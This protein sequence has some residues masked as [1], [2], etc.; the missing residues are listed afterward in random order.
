[1]SDKDLVFLCH[2]SDDKDVVRGLHQNL[3]HDG[4][5]CWL[6][7]VDLVG[8]QNW[9]E[10]ITKAIR[11]SRFVLVCLS[12]NSVS[13]TGYV[14]KELRR[15]LDVADEQP[16]GR[17]FIIPV[18]LKPCEIPQSLSKWHCV[19]L[20]RLNGYPK[21]LESLGVELPEEWLLSEEVLAADATGTVL[22]PMNRINDDH[23]L[24]DLWDLYFNRTVGF[25]SLRIQRS[26][27]YR[28]EFDE[29]MRDERIEKLLC[30]G[31]DGRP[32][33][34]AA[35]TNDLDAM[36]LVSPQYF[37]RLW[38]DHYARRQ[39]WMIEFAVAD[40]DNSVAVYYALFEQICRSV[41][42]RGRMIGID[43]GALDEDARL[44]WRAV[45]SAVLRT[46]G[47]IRDHHNG[48]FRLFEL[49]RT[50]GAAT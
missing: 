48:Q 10:E 30:L 50:D 42:Y 11:R 29:V 36:P 34:M 19:D 35:L 25:N 24:E 7:D 18:R 22:K 41:S 16:E 38:P 31:P 45:E 27:M 26:L 5:N 46:E 32:L 8:G 12:K 4:V 13:K 49:D 39:I 9:D 21:L 37:E 43:V 1:M 33:G 15:A 6:D 2:A 44:V 17:A 47:N 20:Y 28:S 14:Q 23:L 3:T 40:L